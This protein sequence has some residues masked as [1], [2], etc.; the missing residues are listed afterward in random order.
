MST[1]AYMR[2][3]GRVSPDFETAP[4]YPGPHVSPL[5]SSVTHWLDSQRLAYT[6]SL[7]QLSIGMKLTRRYTR[8]LHATTPRGFDGAIQKGAWSALHSCLRVNMLLQ[9]IVPQYMAPYLC[10]HR[11]GAGSAGHRAIQAWAPVRISHTIYTG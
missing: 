1:P 10:C 6:P 3:S 5:L 11:P 8:S 9:Y 2:G 7:R 4:C